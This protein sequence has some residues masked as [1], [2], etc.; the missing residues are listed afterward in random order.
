[1]ILIA[2]VRINWSEDELGSKESTVCFV[3]WHRSV[4]F[5]C[6]KVPTFS[7]K[8]DLVKAHI[9]SE[10]MWAGWTVSGEIVEPPPL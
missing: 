1:M 9:P 6:M 5:K 8:F 4:L 3:F 2:A 10:T 7:L